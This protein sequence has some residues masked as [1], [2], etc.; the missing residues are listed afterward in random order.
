MVSEIYLKFIK[1]L[2]FRK[3]YFFFISILFSP[4]FVLLILVRPLKIIRFGYFDIK[5]IGIIST[6]E[7]YLL[8]S[9]S[10]KK[11]KFL[12]IWFI[13]S[14]IYNRQLYKILKRNFFIISKMSIFFRNLQLI[15]KYFDFFSNHLIK[16]YDGACRLDRGNCI[17][18]LSNNEIKE[19]ERRL[20]KFGIPAKAKI[21]CFTT[22]DQAFLKTISSKDFSYHDY[23]NTNINNYVPAIKELL[24]KNFYVIRMGK[25]VKEKLNIKNKRFI[26]YPFHP[27]KSDLMDFYLAYKCCFW[28]CGNNGMD[29]V[30]VVFRKPLI[31]LNMAP[32]SGMKVTSKKTILCLKIHKN[33]KNKKLSFKEIFKHGV[34]KASR[35][36]EFKK[37]KIK[38][39]ELNPK[40]IKEVV[41]DMI[42]FIKNSWKIKKRDELILINKFSKI[43]KEKSKLIDP[44]FKYKINAIY[45][46]TFLKKNSWFLK[47]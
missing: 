26:D 12:D 37:K 19:G 9:V 15:S 22:R 1:T 31:D 13:D 14:K 18:K 17:L 40:Q 42:N 7:H 34:A 46:P 20:K 24:K 25:V 35:K 10:E 3:I 41:L 44:Q 30:A 36:D 39:F 47:N 43:Y 21:V 5:R 27:F 6:A 29:Q 16:F 4:I 28:I 2:N 33:S 11:N 8:N 23:R 45:S 32:L 38:I